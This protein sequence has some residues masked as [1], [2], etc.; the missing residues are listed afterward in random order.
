MTLSDSERAQLAKMAMGWVMAAKRDQKLTQASIADEM[1][2]RPASLSAMLHGKAPFPGKRLRQLIKICQPPKDDIKWIEGLLSG[3]LKAIIGDNQSN[4]VSAVFTTAEIPVIS[5]A[6]AAGFDPVLEPFDDFVK[7]CSDET[8]RFSAVKENYF[9]LRVEGDSMSPAYPSGTMLLV[10]GGEFPQRGDTV[11]AKIRD[12]GQVIVKNY[13]RKNNIISLNS[14]NP[15]GNSY[16]WDCKKEKDKLSWMWP[17]VEIT[18]R[19]RD[20][21][22]QK[23][24]GVQD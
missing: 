9:A 8:A 16:E 19:L 2:I 5:F 15:A 7:A 21:R 24:R 13:A 23:A 3:D 10:A 11:V 14:I 22:W 4:E 20:K 12:T 6:Q 18:I 17:V 1:G